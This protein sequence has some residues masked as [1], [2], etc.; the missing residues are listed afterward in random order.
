MEKTNQIP[1]SSVI[2]Q[3]QYVSGAHIYVIDDFIH[4]PV[5]SIQW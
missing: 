2:L 4:D 3:I 5:L 1:T